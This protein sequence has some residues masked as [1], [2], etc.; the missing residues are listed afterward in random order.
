MMMTVILSDVAALSLLS[1]LLLLLLW[2]VVAAYVRFVLDV[3]SWIL[4][5]PGK[6]LQQNPRFPSLSSLCLSLPLFAVQPCNR[7]M[8]CA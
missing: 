7:V 2:G 8:C 5:P 6:S 3:W 4:K 1:L